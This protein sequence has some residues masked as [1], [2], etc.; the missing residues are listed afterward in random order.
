MSECSGNC[1]SCQENC[2]SRKEDLRAAMNPYSNI[3][4]VIAVVS[5]TSP[6]P[7]GIST[8]I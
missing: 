3:K 4:K 2:D 6:V 5:G 7:G 8:S 1:S